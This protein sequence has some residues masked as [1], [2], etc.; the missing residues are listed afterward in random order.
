MNLEH[1]VS[2]Y[3]QIQTSEFVSRI[4]Q[5]HRL[6]HYGSNL[7]PRNARRRHPVN[8]NLLTVVRRIDIAALL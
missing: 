5:K 8:E 3:Y 2:Y 6:T 7:G 4:S 1:I